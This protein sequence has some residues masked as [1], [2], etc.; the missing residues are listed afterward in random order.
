MIVKM[1]GWL[2]ATGYQIVHELVDEVLSCWDH[3][4]VKN[5]STIEGKKVFDYCG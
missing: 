3:V 2:C 4:P 1:S 5:K